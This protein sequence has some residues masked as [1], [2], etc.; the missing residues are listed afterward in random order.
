MVQHVY[1]M[2]TGK[3][4]VVVDQWYLLQMSVHTSFLD[5]GQEDI[6]EIRLVFFTTRVIHNTIE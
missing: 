4:K 1:G 3:G 6:L 5:G 2:K